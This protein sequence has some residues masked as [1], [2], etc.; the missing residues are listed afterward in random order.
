VYKHLKCSLKCH[1]HL[2]TVYSAKAGEAVIFQHTQACVHRMNA[3]IYTQVLAKWN[4]VM[5]SGGS[6]QSLCRKWNRLVYSMQ[7][8]VNEGPTIQSGWHHWSLRSA[9]A[10]STFRGKLDAL[11]NIPCIQMNEK[12]MAKHTAGELN[13]YTRIKCMNTDLWSVDSKLQPLKNKENAQRVYLKLNSSLTDA[14]STCKLLIS[15]FNQIC[16]YRI[17]IKLSSEFF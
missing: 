5:Q 17:I 6:H 8:Q 12:Y 11:Y 4:S 9:A 13:Q 2:L 10:M 3:H 16:G 15:L 7:S 1:P 14:V